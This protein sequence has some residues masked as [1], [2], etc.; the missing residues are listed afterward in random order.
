M[1]AELSR[2]VKDLVNYASKNFGSDKIVSPL[3]SCNW[4]WSVTFPYLEGFTICVKLDTGQPCY[5][6]A[7]NIG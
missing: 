2:S 4:K 3:P 7:I 6:H 5:G 1:I